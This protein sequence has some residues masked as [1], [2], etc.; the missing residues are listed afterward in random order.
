MLWSDVLQLR[1]TAAAKAG[2]HLE[3][4]TVRLEAAP[5]YEAE[6][7]TF[8]ET[9]DKIFK[10]GIFCETYAKTLQRSISMHRKFGALH[11]G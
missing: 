1:R 3:R 11:H 5:F 6:N 2:I 9:E 8:H 7:K 10:A 4:L